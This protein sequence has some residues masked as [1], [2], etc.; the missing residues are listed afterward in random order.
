[1]YRCIVF[2]KQRRQ[3]TAVAKVFLIR[4]TSER[5]RYILPSWKRVL[6]SVPI[7]YCGS[8]SCWCV[9]TTQQYLA[10]Q[11][12]SSRKQV[13]HDYSSFMICSKNSKTLLL[14]LF[15]FMTRWLVCSTTTS[16]IVSWKLLVVRDTGGLV[17]YQHY[18]RE[19]LARSTHGCK[20]RQTY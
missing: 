4:W 14:R 17:G 2:Q 7:H 6:S 12:I 15:Y 9:A 20:S 10:L 1:M 16:T 8:T 3:Q 13:I 11:G 19:Q 18:C 5:M